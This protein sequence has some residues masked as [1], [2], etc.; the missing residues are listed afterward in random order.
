M[1][2]CTSFSHDPTTPPRPSRSSRAAAMRSSCRCRQ[3]L[4]GRRTCSSSSSA[5]A[6]YA[7]PRALLAARSDKRVCCSELVDARLAPRGGSRSETAR[8]WLA[9]AWDW[10]MS[11][12][13]CDQGWQVHIAQVLGELAAQPRKGHECTRLDERRDVLV[14]NHAL[15]VLSATGVW[16]ETRPVPPGGMWTDG[17]KLAEEDVEAGSVVWCPERR[18]E[19]RWQG[20]GRHGD[21]GDELLALGGGRDRET[22]EM[23]IDVERRRRCVGCGGMM[24]VVVRGCR[25]TGVVVVS[26]A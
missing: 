2:R 3:P 11:A 4:N 23:C 9:L 10:T 12:A 18:V 6:R 26:E 19:G 25:G 22:E 1:R 21:W 20:D 24:R 13:C 14:V 8:P 17:F 7:S 5:R 16:R 15:C